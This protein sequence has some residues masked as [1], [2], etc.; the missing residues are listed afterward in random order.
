[1]AIIASSISFIS[2]ARAIIAVI[3]SLFSMAAAAAVVV[4]AAAAAAM[5]VVMMAIT[6]TSIVMVLSASFF[7]GALPL[8]LHGLVSRFVV[9]AFVHVVRVGC[10]VGR[11]REGCGYEMCQQG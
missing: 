4:A 9:A 11:R 6:A 5:M 8:W 10:T 3:S 7:G 2:T 1:M